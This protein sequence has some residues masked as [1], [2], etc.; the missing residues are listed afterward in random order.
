[1]GLGSACNPSYQEAESSRITVPS[2]VRKLAPGTLSQR[3]NTTEKGWWNGSRCSQSRN[4][5]MHGF[6][7]AS[8]RP[9]AD[10]GL[11]RFS[12]L[13][14]QHSSPATCGASA[15]RSGSVCSPPRWEQ[16]VL[17]LFVVLWVNA[18]GFWPE[19]R[20]FATSLYFWGWSTVTFDYQQQDASHQG[21]GTPLLRSL[22]WA[23][24]T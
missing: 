15:L 16:W 24:K 4:S 10:S 17:L 21:R 8:T 19:G 11:L 14:S 5:A 9:G 23:S 22:P 20:L 1:M 3:K 18:L 13:W 7:S 12:R 2:Q 6:R